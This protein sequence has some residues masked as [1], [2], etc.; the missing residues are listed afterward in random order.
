[1][2][3]SKE[4]WRYTVRQQGAKARAKARAGAGVL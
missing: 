3:K 1:M 4:D 2:T